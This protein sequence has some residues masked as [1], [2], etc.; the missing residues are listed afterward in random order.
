M[1]D[2]FCRRISALSRW[3]GETVAWLTL[4]MV[5][6]TFTIV[7]LR[8]VFSIN[9][10]WMQEAVTW[11][12]AAVFML[13]A[14]YTLERGEH[15]RVDVFYRHRSRRVR[16]IIDTAGVVLLLLPM[17]VFFVWV[18]LDYVVSSWAIREGSR[19]AQGLPFPATSLVKTFLIVMPTLV[20]LQGIALVVRAWRTERDP[21][22]HGS[23]VL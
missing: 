20:A 19:Q 17:M 6:A 12:H 8:Y 11:M 22:E 2:A 4:A 3:V 15:V 16:A 21:T 9:Y 18:S 10:I 5:L 1:L 13:G 7:V 14:A 23:E